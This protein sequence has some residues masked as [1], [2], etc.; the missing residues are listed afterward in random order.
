MAKQSPII[1]QDDVYAARIFLYSALPLLR[2]IAES[3]EKYGKKFAGKSFVFQV[4]AK[5]SEAEGGA[6]GTHFVV[7]DGNWTVNV[8]KL[9]E[10]PDVEFIFPNLRDF[11]IFFSGKGMP[12]PKIKGWGKLGI[13]VSIL[14]TLLRMAGLLQC[15]DVPQKLEDQIML[16][17]LYFYLLPSGISQLNKLGYP[18]FKA[19]TEPSPD[20]A[21]AFAVSGYPELQSWLRIKAGNSKAGRG[22]YKRCRP[23][24]TMRW[25]SPQHALDI[26]MSKAEMIPY[27][28]QGFL[29]IE[30]AP[31]FGGALGN[32]MFGVAYFAQ[33][34]YLDKLN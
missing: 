5:Y 12:L 15:K 32:L 24:L 26:L 20:R 4:S 29:N 18:E 11:N 8:G 23:F 1:T 13:L 21:Y 22:E 28:E 31:E 2:V 25:D 19:F 34:E 27:I 7:E 14:M 33:G 16:V 10:N 3:E 6:M 9:H 17:K 30:G